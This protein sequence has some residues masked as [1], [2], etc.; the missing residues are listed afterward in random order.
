M[1][2]FFILSISLFLSVLAYNQT[3]DDKV[4]SV[5]NLMSLEEKI[6][7]MTQI[8]RNSFTEIQDLA[9]YG[10]GSILSGGG[11]G[12]DVNALENWI[13]MYDNFQ[14]VA[15]QSSLG[16]PMIYGI[17]A[18]HGNNNVYGAVIFPHNIGL[19]CTWDSTLIREVNQVVA[20]EVA[21]TGIDWTFAPCIAVPRNERWGR[22]Y[23]G[24]GETPEVQKIMAKE[25]VIGLQG[26]DLSSP[27][28]ILACAKHFVGD[29]GT[30]NGIDQGNTEVSEEELRNIHMAG[31]IDAIEAGVGTVMASYSSWNGVKLHGNQYLLTDVLKTELGFEGFVISDW[32]GVDQVDED[33]RTA[34]KRS[35]NAGVDMVMV[36]DRYEVFI[37]HLTSLV[38]DAEVS[39]DRIDDAVRRILKQ[40]F[41][42]GL[43]DEPYADTS[44]SSSFGSQEHRDVARQAVRESMVLLSS[45]NDVLPLQKNNQKILV[46]GSLAADLGAQCG[47]WTIW[48]QGGSGDITIGTDIL[49][50]IENLA[51]G[52]EVVYS[53]SGSFDGD[54]DVAVVVVGEK[55]PYAEGAG[56][57]VSLD[58]D[59]I[60]ALMLK[61]LKEAGIPT[62]ALIVSGRPMILGEIPTYA[63]ALFAVWYPGSEGDGI[64]E[65]LY[66]DY[67]P[68]G[69]LT[70]SWPKDM[71]QVPINVGDSAYN[72]LYVYKHGL[73]EFPTSTA[74]TELLP[75]AATTNSEGNV[76]NISLSDVV[77]QLSAITS[78]FAITVNG[79]V[80]SNI[81]SSVSVATYDGSMIELHLNY[82]LHET[83]KIEISF[84]GSGIVSSSLSLNAFAD[85]Y[86]YNA[87]GNEIIT[88]VIPGTVQAEDYYDSYGVQTESCSDV[89]G[90]LNVGYID[91]GDWMRYRIE[92]T[93]SGEYEIV[94]R[95]SG[96]SFGTILFKFNDTIQSTVTFSST[97]GWQNWNDFT[98]TVYLEAG[99]YT[100]DAIAQT[101]AFNI[102]Y[103]EFNYTGNNINAPIEIT[104][105]SVYPN[106][107][108][109]YV[110]VKFDAN[111]D[112]NVQ[113]SLIDITGKYSRLLYKGAAG[114]GTYN[115]QIDENLARGIYFIELKDNQKRYF[116]KIIKN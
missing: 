44:L 59:P 64:A 24:P 104:D 93:Q 85:L 34:I 38:Q 1:K 42:L 69:K 39:I 81:I 9:T 114:D 28:T 11:S 74:A 72:P 53:A 51:E 54:E 14:S 36:P 66:G 18:V 45:K 37:G 95:I 60:D 94:S 109:N 49:T 98:S 17:D 47:G 3:V 65:V 29:G 116:K 56:D 113:I 76:I 82:A 99:V 41:L 19:G 71:S 77:T 5:L 92:V 112:Q 21:A 103:F 115:F 91:S 61:N 32:K 84:T 13:S 111:H 75:L 73:Q 62:I 58:L 68:T 87:V 2:H 31:Y 4:D 46:A 15:M 70:H 55:T 63:D 101:N 80:Q 97:N 79:A 50:G 89:G 26:T 86:V 8:E 27:E 43:F 25:A 6:G 105:I 83:D 33:Y 35:I 7:Q 107:V 48:W 102:N 100:M 96:Y 20:K 108:V 110:N 22:T 106:P 40:K 52:S 30:T 90:G 16:I 10:I 67:L 78:D 23:E 57:R 12:P 88:Q